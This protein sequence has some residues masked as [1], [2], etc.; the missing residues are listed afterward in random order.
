VLEA[1]AEHARAEGCR[2]VSYAADVSRVSDID[3]VSARL[4]ADFGQVDLLVHCAGALALGTVEEAHVQ[5]LDRQYETNVRG[6][7]LLTQALLPLL[8]VREGQVVFVNST[9]G[10]VARAGVSQYAASKHA[11]R[12]LAESLR[13]EVNPDGVRVLSVFLGRTA[14][15][16]Q[17]W[18]HE[19]EG[20]QYAPERLIQPD[21]VASIVLCALSLP[22]TA[23]VT[24]IRVRPMMKPGWPVSR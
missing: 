5:E 10:L 17:A 9:A 16:M 1:V 22:R 14:T 2:V 13:E 23:E 12:A 7:F 4:R 6:P 3:G 8:K 18:V 15:P 24:E 20:K 19:A 11:L 21:D